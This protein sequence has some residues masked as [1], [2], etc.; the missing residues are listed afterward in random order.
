MQ[1]DELNLCV[2]D[3]DGENKRLSRMPNSED[4]HRSASINNKCKRKDKRMALSKI[5]VRQI[6]PSTLIG[7]KIE[8]GSKNTDC[9]IIADNENVEQIKQQTVVENDKIIVEIENELKCNVGKEIEN[10]SVVIEE[11]KPN[12]IQ[13]L[14]LTS[15]QAKVSKKK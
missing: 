11:K 8:D 14:Q 5:P 4:N 1:L 15:E 9:I 2:E 12:G 13:K 10:E 6:K 7:R 3:D